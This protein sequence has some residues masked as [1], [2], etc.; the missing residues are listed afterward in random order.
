MSGHSKWSKIRHKKAI[1][2]AKRGKKFSKLLQ[3]ITTASREGG[4]DI[5]S[6]PTLRLLVEK[7]KA[8]SLPKA[9][10]ER[11]IQ[12]GAGISKDGKKLETVYYEGFSSDGIGVVVEAITDN[13]NRTISDLRT[14]FS[15][16][17]GRLAD[18]GSVTWNFD[19]V[20][21]IVIAC[22]KMKKNEK[23]GGDDIF[24]PISPDIITDKVLEI[25]GIRDIEEPYSQG[26]KYFI[27]IWTEPKLLKNVQAEISKNG[28]VIEE[29]ELTKIV[30]TPKNANEKELDHLSNLVDDLE[31]YEDVQHVWT[32]VQ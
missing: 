12:R 13:N 28:W 18:K 5:D 15:K 30:Q 25:D 8:E 26:D 17:G 9:N 31:N 10:L 4:P 23:F 29:I 3:Q 6:N 32:E 16:H 7:A 19:N 1:N 14:I 24:E 11:A 21:R 2:D 20:G 22:G 27:E